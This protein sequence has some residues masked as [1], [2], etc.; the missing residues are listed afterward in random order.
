ME[1]D[2]LVPFGIMNEERPLHNPSACCAKSLGWGGSVEC[3]VMRSGRCAYA[4]HMGA[5]FLCRHPESS[6]IATR[7][8]DARRINAGVD[9]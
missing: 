7:S 4:L 1:T 5:R 9:S 3:I 6:L 2:N 8:G